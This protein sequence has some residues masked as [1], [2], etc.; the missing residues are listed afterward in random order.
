[1]PVDFEVESIA[2]GL[3]RAGIGPEPTLVSWLGVVPY[4]SVD[5]IGATLR[6]LPPCSL[7]V[8]Y[9]VPEHTWPDAVR[10]ASKTFRAM[11]TDAGEPPRTFFEPDRFAALLGDHRCTLVHDA[12]FQDVERR[13][14]LPA[15]SIG[16]ERI[17][18][19]TKA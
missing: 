8:S 17:T 4:L 9:A 18:L 7:A 12:G 10:A 15:L 1:M 13:Y 5:A 2:D 11:A 16:G 3:T 19:A 14:G 6:D